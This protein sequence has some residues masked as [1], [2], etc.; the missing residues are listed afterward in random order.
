M[1]FVSMIFYAIIACLVWSLLKIYI[2]LGQQSSVHGSSS[3]STSLNTSSSLR[4][5]SNNTIH[6]QFSFFVIIFKRFLVIGDKNSFLNISQ[7]KI[8]IERNP[9]PKIYFV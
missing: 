2:L 8:K 1:F 9:D 3:G 6:Y 7:Q 5:I 4:G